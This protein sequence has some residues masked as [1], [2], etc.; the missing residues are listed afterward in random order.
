MSKKKAEIKVFRNVGAD[1]KS[2]TLLE[3]TYRH[4]DGFPELTCPEFDRISL[5]KYFN[6]NPAH[7]KAIDIK[8]SMIGGMGYEFKHE[9]KS[10]PIRDFLDNLYN[11]NGH[12]ISATQFFKNLFAVYFNLEQ[13]MI[14]IIR[15]NGKMSNWVV[16]DPKYTY[17]PRKDNV[18]YRPYYHQVLPPYSDN[19]VIDRKFRV[20]GDRR[21]TSLNE[22]FV[23]EGA[24]VT[25]DYYPFPAY[26]AALKN[27][28][29]ND[30][31]LDN[32]L[33]YY[34]EKVNMDLAILIKGTADKAMLE[35]LENKLSGYTASS[36]KNTIVIASPTG[37]IKIQ[38]LEN[39]KL[40]PNS[41]KEYITNEDIVFEVH[42]IPRQLTRSKS[43]GVQADT[44]G[45]KIIN[46]TMIKPYTTAWNE[47]INNLFIREFGI[48]A[49]F[50][51]KQP[52]DSNKIEDSN[53]RERDG[54][55][56]QRAI[57]TGSYPAYMNIIGNYQ[58]MPLTEEQFNHA[59]NI[60]IETQIKIKGKT[61]DNYTT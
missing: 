41:T 52:D 56:T 15:Y 32:S 58:E 49:G 60:Y 5:M 29:V 35:K 13:A 45:I 12:P 10:Q 36:G 6:L 48:D 20:Y 19:K 18:Y 46:E 37:E 24:T 30:S 42:N 2:K 26:V 21:F 39:F 8:S 55:T 4:I 57:E 31:S 25:D 50:R 54:R 43:D 34:N 40:D 11:V 23:F 28:L 1:V 59:Y 3:N 9:D 17:V 47:Q 14:E 33:A 51:F 53:V 44:E 7:R 38:P 22:L 61:N 27:M 16:H